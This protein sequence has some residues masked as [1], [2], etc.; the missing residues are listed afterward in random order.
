MGGEP[1]FNAFELN[2][3]RGRECEGG[4]E[5]LCFGG[6]GEGD[7]GGDGDVGLKVGDRAGEEGWEGVSDEVL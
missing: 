3:Q 7:I 6:R 5:L 1:S 4:E 2:R